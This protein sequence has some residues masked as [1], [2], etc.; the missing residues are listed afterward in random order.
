MQIFNLF[1]LRKKIKFTV[2]MHAFDH[3]HEVEIKQDAST[4]FEP[5]DYEELKFVN[6]HIKPYEDIMIGFAV[7]LRERHKLDD[8]ISLLECK[9]AAYNDLR[10]FCISCGRKQYFDDEW[11]K[12][13]GDMPD[14]TTYIT[15]SIDRLN[16]L[17]KNYQALKQRENIRLSVLP[18][19]DAK[20]LAFI[21]K[22]QPILQTDIYKA[23]DD[24][25]KEDIKERL[26][27]WD[28]GKLI[29][30]AKHGSTYIVSMPNS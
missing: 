4:P 28:K 1:K 29:A 30:R 14:G 8:E 12:P 22:N 7:A 23:F 26:Y 25:V 16:Y 24:S 21:D 13:L 17:K 11:G 5:L 3:G 18:T 6:D 15:P 27:F 2:E 20:L 9:I 10:Q 19:L